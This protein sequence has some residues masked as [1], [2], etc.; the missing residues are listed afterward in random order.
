MSTS[1]ET[2]DYLIEMLGDDK[3]FSTRAM[4]GEYALYVDQKVVGLV[5]NDQLYIK[6]LPSS[7][8]LKDVCEQDSPYPGAKKHYLVEES[9]LQQI[10]DLPDVL[11]SVANSLPLPKK[12]NSKKGTRS[13]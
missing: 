4:F 3:R 8:K 13:K 9:Q 2:I 12:K 1:K 7:D 6:I 11:F 5:C 10:S